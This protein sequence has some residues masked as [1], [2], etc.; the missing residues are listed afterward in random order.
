[1]RKLLILLLFCGSVF[2]A[3]NPYRIFNSF[4]AGE[5]SPLLNSREDLAKFQS[6]CSVM[7]N[8]IPIPQGGAEKRLGLKYIAGVKTNSLKTRLLPFEFSTSQS[9][10]IETGNQYMRF[11]TNSAVVFTNFTT[12]DLSS[13]TVNIKAHWLL[14]DNLATSVVIDDDGATHN[15]ALY[16]GA[17]ATG[18]ATQETQDVSVANDAGTT[19]KAFDM[20]ALTGGVAFVNVSDSGDFTF[21]D[22]SS[23]S[24]LSLLCVVKLNSDS[25]REDENY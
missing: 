9:Y 14:N 24:P 21:G 13:H 25:T 16:D 18:G 6:G 12:E 7:E 1:M 23:D 3:D 10:I 22:G 4:N 20:S 15:G 2:A 8:L 11:F 5:L 17:N 19:N